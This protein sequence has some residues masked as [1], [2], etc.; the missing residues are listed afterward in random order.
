[1]EYFKQL[2]PCALGGR[3]YNLGYY[4]PEIDS[5]AYYPI[6]CLVTGKNDKKFHIYAANNDNKAKD[7]ML[8]MYYHRHNGINNP[9][10]VVFDPDSAL[11]VKTKDKIS[12]IAD[13]TLSSLSAMPEFLPAFMEK[14]EQA[15]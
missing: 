13:K 3:G 15:G 2:V 8:S 12:D 1:M 7:A 4:Y 11:P 10:C 9:C 5:E 14:Y 6:D